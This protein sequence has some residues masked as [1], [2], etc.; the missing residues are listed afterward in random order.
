MPAYQQ[1]KVF[2]TNNF[3]IA[4][5]ALH[6]LVGLAILLV[7]CWLFK[8]PLHWRGALGLVLLAAVMAE[9]LDV[10]SDLRA[11]GTW[12]WRESAKDILLTLSAPVMVA[13]FSKFKR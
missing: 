9:V 8:K 11:Y 13:L 1:F 2:L 10:I 4:H 6:V 5:D 7:A 3:P 12:I